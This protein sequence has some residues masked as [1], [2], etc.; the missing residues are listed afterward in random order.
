M[1]ERLALHGG[2]PVRDDFLV[3][4]KP[5]IGE[6]EIEELLDTVRSGWLGTGPKTRR[7]EEMFAE[8]IGV[9][10][11]VAVS[12]CTGALFL[13]LRV[14][15]IGP[16]DEVITT[17]LTFVATA[18]VIQ[19]VG[20]R[21]VFVDVDPNTGL[22]DVGRIPAAVTSRTRAILPVH[23]YGGPCDMET[24]RSIAD[25]SG[26]RVIGDAAHAIEAAWRDRKVGAQGDLACF[27]FYATKNICT[28]EGGMVT[29]D[30]DHL[31][32][33]LRTLRLHGLSSDAWKRFGKPG[34]AV[35]EAIEVGY[36]QNLTD[37]QASLGLHQLSRVER[38]LERRADIWRRYDEAF[39]DSQELDRPSTNVENGRHALHIYALNLRLD[40]LSVDRAG[41]V[42]ALQA[43]NVGCGIH[44]TPVHLHP[45]YREEFGYVEGDFPRAERAGAATLS[46]PL[47]PCLTGQEVDDVIRA[48]RKVADAY[49]L[50]ESAP[51]DPT[52][53][54]EGTD[55]RSRVS[56]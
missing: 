49:R 53:H 2:A 24:I 50:G 30:D 3:F 54:A 44:Y 27:S 21:P 18:N 45:I 39:A 17:P 37:M 12:S 14:L 19:H 7:F 31:A 47:S 15:G 23:L 1:P 35:Y 16:G 46:L 11:A 40:R 52:L 56:H 38:N 33:R 6:A 5:C 36:K 26:L 41:F 28:G 42:S 55:N 8:Y 13:A 25:Q 22:I 48:V 10:H 43:E 34:H 9:Q 4:G 32:A 29:T 51:T 20:A